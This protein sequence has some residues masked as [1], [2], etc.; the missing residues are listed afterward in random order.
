MT[1]N[2]VRIVFFAMFLLGLAAVASAQ[3]VCTN[4]T[5]AGTWGTTM[6]GTLIPS[7]GAVPFAAVARATYDGMGNYSGTQTRSNNGTVSRVAFQ[8]TYTV[9]SDCSG[10]KTTRGYDQ[11]GN[12]LNTVE[13]DF[14]LVNYGKELIEIFTSL[15]LPNGTTVPAVITAHSIKLFPLEWPWNAWQ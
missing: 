9:N 8:G 6:T 12:L 5:V 4:A 14:V 3:P 15:T 13:Q 10:K 1:R 7:T 11:S 2:I